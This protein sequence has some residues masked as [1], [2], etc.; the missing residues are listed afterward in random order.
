MNSVQNNYKEENNK[1]QSLVL[2]NR[3][4]LELTGVTDVLA[5][6]EYCVQLDTV[7]G[8]LDIEGSG[9]S[10]RDVSIESGKVCIIGKVS[11]MWYTE[12]K[13]KNSE[14]RN[15]FFGGKKR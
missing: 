14:K 10:V 1:E 12:K 15:P 5:F 6:D 13:Q 3:S 2:K 8:A 7:L 9:L 11:G 4:V